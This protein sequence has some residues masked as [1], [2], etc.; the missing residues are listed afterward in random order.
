M[1][2]RYLVTGGAGF[3]GSHLAQALIGQ[4]AAVRVLDD[5]SSGKEANL[6]RGAEL[7]VGDVADPATVTRAAAGTDGCFHL[8][9]VASVQR[10]TEAWLATHRIN[11]GGT[12]NVFEAARAFAKGAYPVVYASS[13]AIYGDNPKLPLAETAPL[14][15]LSPYGADKA[16]SELHARAAWASFGIPSTG[17]RFF[18]IFGP[19]QDPASPYSGVI[20]IFATRI[21]QDRPLTLFGDGGQTRDFVYVGDVVRALLAAMTQTS[22]G[23]RAFNVCTGRA[24]SL[25]ALIAALEAAAGRP[26]EVETLPARDGDIRHSQGD[27]AA[28]RAGLG[29]SAD[30]PFAEGIARLMQWIRSG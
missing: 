3:I 14:A 5:L 23:A 2:K 19:R 30:T 26:A 28:L 17:L 24:R 6:P 25:R 9:A 8:A 7:L 22:S 13:A 10:S 4:G 15:P 12:I 18:N 20:S 1:A 11:L 29:V 21:A 27:P 16:G